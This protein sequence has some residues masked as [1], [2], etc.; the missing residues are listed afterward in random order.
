MNKISIIEN[1]NSV[2]KDITLPSNNYLNDKYPGILQDPLGE[3]TRNHLSGKHWKDLTP[4]IVEY[5]GSDLGGLSPEEMRFYLPG[6]MIVCINSFHEVG[7]AMNSLLSLLTLPGEDENP[8]RFKR[9]YEIAEGLT[10]KQKSA[11]RLFLEFLKDK[12]VDKY[13][14][15]FYDNRIPQ[16]ALDRYWEKF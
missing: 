1:I 9:F 15:E 5:I 6:F 8:N 12:F 3:D 11:V 4:D 13:P 10:C 14:D 2:F 7:L 16:V